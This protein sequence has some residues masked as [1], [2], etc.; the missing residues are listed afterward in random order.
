ML[1]A[2]L[3][4]RARPS[5]ADAA[6]I[7]TLH[8]L[9]SRLLAD[10]PGRPRAEPIPGHPA[11]FLQAITMYGRNAQMF[12]IYARPDLREGAQA[13]PIVSFGVAVCAGDGAA[14]LWRDL[15]V[16]PDTLSARTDPEAPPDAV[17]WIGVA[18]H[19]GALA[20]P[21]AAEWLGDFEQCIAF[22]VVALALHAAEE[23]R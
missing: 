12:R 20:R 7:Y 13:L 17:P 2:G 23:R 5:E 1:A 3:T 19:S 8:P 15:H 16:L 14:A 10:G 11:Y 22:T 4:D 6:T 18:V 21:E 9:I